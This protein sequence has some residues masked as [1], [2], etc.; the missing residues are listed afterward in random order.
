MFVGA[1]E[2]EVVFPSNPN[3]VLRGGQTVFEW[4]KGQQLLV[5]R[6]AVS[7]PDFPDG[8]AVIS[9]DPEEQVYTQHYFDSRGVIRLYTMTFNAG[10]W[11]L[12]RT[13]A[14]FSSLDF[15]Q[16]YIGRFMP[17]RSAIRGAWEKSF[18]GGH[19]WEKDFDLAYI[20]LKA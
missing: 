1:W 20:R 13:S 7:S 9:F 10:E 19:H 6:T 2:L 18:D 8:I 15:S 12:T 14:D 4:M 16:R 17:D 3:E 11:A 5:E